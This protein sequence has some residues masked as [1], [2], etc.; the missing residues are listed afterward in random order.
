MG[1][2]S[3]CRFQNTLSDLRDCQGRL[4]ELLEFAGDDVENE[5]GE[6]SRDELEAAKDLAYTCLQISES[7]AE[8][9]NVPLDKLTHN[10]LHDALDEAQARCLANQEEREA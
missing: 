9:L 6:L 1:N 7:F 4:Q 8:Y 10:K 2:M 3:Y 5:D